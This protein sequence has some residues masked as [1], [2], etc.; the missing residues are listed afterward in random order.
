MSEKTKV[1]AKVAFW[2]DPKTLVK[3]D[4]EATL[5]AAVARD[6]ISSGIAEAVVAKE[7]A[8]AE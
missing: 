6:L 3:V 2:K 4:G 8:P 5:D 1:K 7:K